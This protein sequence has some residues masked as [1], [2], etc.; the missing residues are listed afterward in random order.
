MRAFIVLV[1]F[2]LTFLLLVNSS[3]AEVDLTPNTPA[4]VQA[5]APASSS[6]VIFI[7]D[8]AIPSQSAVILP[9]TGGCSDPYT[10]RSGDTLSQIAVNCGSTLAFLTQVNPQMGH[11]DCMY[12]GQLINIHSS[13]V[14][15]PAPCRAQS[16][17]PVQVEP[18]PVRFEPPLV[19]I[20][21]AAPVVVVL[22]QIVVPIT[23]A[24]PMLVSGTGLQVKAIHFPPNMP[25][26][27]GIGPRTT[28]YTVVASGITDSNGSLTTQI[29]IPTAPDTQTPWVVIV[30][31]TN[32]APLQILSEL[33]TIRP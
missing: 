22:P 9:V 26:N 24:I 32:P 8:S 5:D 21:P 29:T 16:E 10:V 19:Q 23:G 20:E 33:F 30:M 6:E 2:F 28:G 17:P 7:Q 1:I 11:V 31:T 27:I 3:L 12:P 13:T 4:T 25:V 14:Q 18:P 15:Q